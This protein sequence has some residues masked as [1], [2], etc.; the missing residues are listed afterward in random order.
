MAGNYKNKTLKLLIFM[1]E[2]KFKK[3]TAFSL[4]WISTWSAAEDFLTGKHVDCRATNHNYLALVR[5]KQ[6]AQGSLL[7]SWLSSILY[8][9][10]AFKNLA[11]PIH[12]NVEFFTKKEKQ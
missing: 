10:M 3:I 6:T 12:S 9:Y 7:M 2:C 5:T 1:A 8:E 4:F 11:S